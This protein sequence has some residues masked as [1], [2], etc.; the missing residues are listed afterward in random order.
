M[1]YLQQ[2]IS[3]IN[4][5]YLVVFM[6]LTYALKNPLTD[7]LGSILRVKV[8]KIWTV[9][10]IG[11]VAAVPFWVLFNH[12]RMIL[13][14]TWSVGTSLHDMIIKFLLQKINKR[15]QEDTYKGKV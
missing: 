5:Y 15:E 7:L 9:F 6:A 4:L 13:L 10:I 2:F 11:T 1:E 8:V 14:I 12:D 3:H